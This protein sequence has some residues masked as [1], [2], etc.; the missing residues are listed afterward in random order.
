MESK[1]RKKNG[2]SGDAALKPYAPTGTKK[3]D[4]GEGEG[5]SASITR[6]R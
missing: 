4:E 1:N 3:K 2:R 5:N 6:C